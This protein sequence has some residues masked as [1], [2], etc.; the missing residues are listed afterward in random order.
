MHAEFPEQLGAD[1]FEVVLCELRAHVHSEVA[2]RRLLAGDLLVQV[3][4]EVPKKVSGEQERLLRELAELEHEA[5][6]PHRKS[7][8]ENLKQFFD[9]ETDSSES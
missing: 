3:F 8:L 4:I 2:R 5:V 9:P 6:L 1:C 7:F